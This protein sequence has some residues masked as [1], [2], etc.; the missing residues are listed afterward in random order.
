MNRVFDISIAEASERSRRLQ[1]EQTRKQKLLEITS[2]LWTY[3]QRKQVQQVYLIGSIL[4]EYRFAPYSDIDIVIAGL[5]PEEYFLV[6][7]ELEELLGTEHL[8]LI[9]MEKCCFRDLV[10]RYGMRIL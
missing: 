7:G 6:W 8:D 1:Q 9:E 2:R 3:F 10:Q 4:Q 5:A